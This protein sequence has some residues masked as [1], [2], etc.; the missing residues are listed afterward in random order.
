MKKFSDKRR[1][2]IDPDNPPLTQ[3]ELDRMRPAS[4]VLPHLVREYKRGRGERGPQKEPVKERVT[5]RLD[6]DVVEYFRTT[7][8]GWQ[9]RLNDAL[10]A[11]IKKRA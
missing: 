4:E 8:K 6:A 7:G 11:Q 1:E 9:T 5:I 3:E 2:T 10:K